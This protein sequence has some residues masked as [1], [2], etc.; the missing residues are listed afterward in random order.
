[1]ALRPGNAAITASRH[2]ALPLLQPV[3]SS[4]VRA[5]PTHR[6]AAAS[7]SQMLTHGLSIRLTGTV[8]TIPPIHG[9]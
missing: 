3:I 5:Q 6:P 2:A 7:I 8:S 4:I 1:M 9:Q